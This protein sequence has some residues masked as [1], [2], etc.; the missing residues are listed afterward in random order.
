MPGLIAP[1][2]TLALALF[3]NNLMQNAIITGIF[4]R[5]ALLIFHFLSPVSA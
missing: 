4:A 3:A 2:T 1:L 5:R